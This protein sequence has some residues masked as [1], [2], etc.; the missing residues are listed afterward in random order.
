MAFD[1]DAALGDL[2]RVA[3]E[4]RLGKWRFR[5][6]RYRLERTIMR[7]GTSVFRVSA[8]VAFVVC[9]AHAVETQTRSADGLRAGAAKVEI[10]PKPSDL[11]TAT[12]SIRDP[13]FA[14][15]VVVADGSG[16]AVLVGLDMGGAST[17]L[18]NDAITRASA[19][20]GYPVEH[21]IISATHTHS[22]NTQGL[23][24]GPPTMRT[25]ADAIVEAVKTAKSR[26][27]PARIGYGHTNVDLNVN[28]DL[29]NHKLEW[30][31][32][33]NPT[34]PSDKTLAIVEFLGADNVPIAVYMNYAMHPIN[35]YLSG[36]ISADFP[37]EASRYIEELFDNRTIA[38]FS[39]G[40][41]GDQNPR[42]F[43]S[44]TTFMGQRAALTQGRG[45]FVQTIGAPPVAASTSTQGFNA[46]QASAERQAIPAESLEAY[47]KTGARTGEYV[48]MLGS[49]LASSAVRVMRE[50][51]QPTGSATI[52]AGQQTFACPGR[53]RN[54]ADNPAR[55]NVFPGYKD[56]PD[57]NLKVGVLRIGDVHFVSVNG[58]VYSQ[59]G[60]RIKA[61]APASQAI[62]VTLAN[63]SANSGYIYSDEA[64]SHLTFQVIGSRL[65]PGCAEGK[66][67]ST[68]LDLMRRSQGGV[69]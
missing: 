30:R 23:G 44:P 36:V 58:E 52:W 66:I 3:S 55:E 67:V 40:A 38:V 46:Q 13:L 5:D 1:G 27:A 50:S 54:D 9:L 10:T 7:T 31:Q 11:T 2:A 25:V 48:H 69:Q 63:G 60:M 64:Y 26:L 12:D 57:V 28:R 35:F 49:M 6:R 15:A 20:T 43:R 53:V 61:E 59:I 32:E 47:R 42:D 4:P 62:V 34:G 45:P 17:A 21:F 41:A 37:G 39:Q 24:Q 19:A 8:A 16:C 65:K 56:G 51:I 22:S 29:F 68:A 18:V 33:P 14:R